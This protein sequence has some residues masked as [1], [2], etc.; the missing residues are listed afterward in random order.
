M[1]VTEC[2]V[3]R[4]CLGVQGI[5]IKTQAPLTDWRTKRYCEDEIGAVD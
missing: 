2:Y 1:I 3:E 5:D 4:E